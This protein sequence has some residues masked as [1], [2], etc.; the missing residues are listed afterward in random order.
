MFQINDTVL[1]GMEGVCRITGV[2]TKSFGGEAAEY[3]ELRP[4]Y[5]SNS[6]VFVPLQN[7]RLLSKMKRL[8]SA[9]EICELIGS[10]GGEQLPWIENEGERKEAFHDILARGDRRELMLLIHTL[11]LQKEERSKQGRQ[12]YQSDEKAFKEAEH[13]LYDE[14]AQVLDIKQDQVV[15]FILNQIK[16]SQ[17]EPTAPAES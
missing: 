16:K 9:G 5:K 4:V 2:V 15:P 1:Y 10:I 14:F 3:Y 8:L 13:L 17:S 11:H 7:D 6:T 12:L